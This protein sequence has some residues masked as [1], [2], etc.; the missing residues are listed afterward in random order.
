[1][2]LD[3][4]S[5]NSRSTS[6]TRGQHPVA[7]RPIP[8]RWT[9]WG[10]FDWGSAAPARGRLA[11]SRAGGCRRADIRSSRRGRGELRSSWV[12]PGEAT[13][14]ASDR[15]PPEY[16]CLPLASA[17]SR[18]SRVIA[19]CTSAPTVLIEGRP[20]TGP[21]TSTSTK[22]SPR[23]MLQIVCEATFGLPA[24]IQSALPTVACSSLAPATFH[25]GSE[26]VP[27]LRILMA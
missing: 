19:F 2:R 17:C 13:A 14:E 27:A 9:R 22:P 26:A 5:G 3:S 12:G 21:T 8:G 6:S 24:K 11:R 16:R 18:Q 10:G 4:G 7:P 20:S 25:C 15:Q 1:V 23:G